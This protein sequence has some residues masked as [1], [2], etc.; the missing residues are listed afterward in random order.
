VT[1]FAMTVGLLSLLAT[2]VAAESLDACLE[3]QSLP[4]I[5][6]VL[7][8]QGRIVYA[9]VTGQRDGHVTRARSLAPD[10]TPLAQVFARADAPTGGLEFDVDDDRVCAVVALTESELDAETKVILSTGL[11]YAAHAKEAGGGDVFLFPKPAA[12][13]RPYAPVHAPAGVTLLDYEVELAF[14]LL[15]D[16]DPFDPPTSDELLARSAFF[17]SNDVSDREAIVRRAEF[18]GPGTGYAEGKGQPGFLPAGPWMIRGTEL[19][20]ALE[21]CGADGLGL[22]LFVDDEREPRQEA[23]TRRMILQP[24]ALV[25]R[26]GTWIDEHGR[27]S[28][29]P[30]HRPGEEPRFYPLAV[31]DDA[32]RL[33]AGSIVQTGTPEGVALNAP[34]PLG[35]TLR[36]ALR[37]RSPFA[38]FLAEEKA[39]AATG[40][41]RYLAPGSVVR[42]G[43]DGLGVQ[44]IPIGEAG[45]RAAPHPCDAG[46]A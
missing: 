25:A 1:R 44:R 31:P 46:E 24:A 29:M 43:I 34:S 37:L 21:R 13:T 2:P 15:E 26:I 45:G 17:L 30:F 28:N 9:R 39:R 40:G 11:N 5:A 3:A 10:G 14:V 7:D 22:R 18:F 35:V 41:T 27:R 36:G 6:R 20:Q 33:T 19:W 16:L 32:A 42:A 4:R 8:P 23:S 12:P 38:Q